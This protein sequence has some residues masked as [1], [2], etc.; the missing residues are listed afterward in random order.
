MNISEDLVRKY[1]V[2]S[3]Y[4]ERLELTVYHGT[5]I[6]PS[7]LISI[8]L[9]TTVGNTSINLSFKYVQPSFTDVGLIYPIRI[10]VS[11]QEH[12]FIDICRY[13]NSSRY[14]WIEQTIFLLPDSIN[15]PGEEIK[16]EYS[17]RI[18]TL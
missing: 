15:L 1:T 3:S 8:L 16:E 12:K 4:I 6:L 18:I 5:E 11:L 17:G 14:V 2:L 13:N 9:I 10:V 7:S